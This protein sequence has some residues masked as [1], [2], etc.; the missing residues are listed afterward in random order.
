[1]NGQLICDRI[2]LQINGERKDNSV[3]ISGTI[4]YVKKIL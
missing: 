2:D 4:V 3:N 1:M